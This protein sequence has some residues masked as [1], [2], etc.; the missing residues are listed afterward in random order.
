MYRLTNTYTYSSRHE[1]RS[2]HWNYSLLEWFRSCTAVLILLELKYKNIDLFRQFSHQFNKIA[3]FPTID[4]AVKLHN[5]LLNA[6]F[7]HSN[8]F[9]RKRLKQLQIAF[10]E[11]AKGLISQ[12]LMINLSHIPCARYTKWQPTNL[13][14]FKVRFVSGL[15]FMI[16][17]RISL[18]ILLAR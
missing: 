12:S 9:S 17:K 14:R 3:T 15:V 18:A 11:P 16:L 13:T 8:I 1:W 2:Q 6:N 7:I 10:V 4:V 5:Y